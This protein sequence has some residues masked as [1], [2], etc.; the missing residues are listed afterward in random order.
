MREFRYLGRIYTNNDDDTRYILDNLDRAQKRWNSIA[1]ILKRESADAVCMAKIYPA[2]VQA[3]LLYG[4]DSWVVS[5][6]NMKRLW[7]FHRRALRYMMGDH[8]KKDGDGVCEYPDH[9][10][11]E[12]QCG[13]FGIEVYLERRGTLWKYLVENKGDLLREV[14]VTGIHYGDIN[15]KL[16]WE[17]K[18]MDKEAMKE[19]KYFWFK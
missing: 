15:K 13:L 6:R 17:Q 2:V 7:S 10:E 19:L 14:E 5:D 18:W 11:L 4:A 9:E 12:K 1:K 16:W 3:V 8:M